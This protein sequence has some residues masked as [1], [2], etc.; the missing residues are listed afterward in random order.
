MHDFIFKGD[1]VVTVE[2]T[3]GIA[4]KV[5]RLYYT[6]TPDNGNK[7]FRVNINGG[8]L[9]SLAPRVTINAEQRLYVIRN[10]H[11]YS[12][13]GFDY[14]ESRM[15]GYV[16]YLASRGLPLILA[17]DSA[18]GTVARYA[19]YESAVAAIHGHF[20]RTGE[21][22]DS[23]LTPQLKGLEGKRVEVVDSYGE[24]RRFKV[25]KSTGW[26]PC[27]LEIASDRLHGGG[28]VY[29]SPFRSVRV[30]S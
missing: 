10:S 1:A 25:G 8:G 26:I 16:E 9:K 22:C 23:E 21:R 17:P 11:G 30:V 2:N 4:S 18:P 14:L 5:G 27:H 28:P 15:A 20:K 7:P 3:R 12:C 19:E 6:V 24:T 13:L 29:G